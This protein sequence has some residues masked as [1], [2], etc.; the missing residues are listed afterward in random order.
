[1]RSGRPEA[2]NAIQKVTRR[3][4][5]GIS[6]RKDDA[7]EEKLDPG[8]I[9]RRLDVA[10]T[11]A[12]ITVTLAGALMV[13]WTFVAAARRDVAAADWGILTVHLLVAGIV[14]F[15][16]YGGLVYMLPGRPSCAG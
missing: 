11:W 10:L 8:R 1:M 4:H 7:V 2:G 6:L 9:T 5:R 13:S 15:L 12:A 16:I 3:D 14:A